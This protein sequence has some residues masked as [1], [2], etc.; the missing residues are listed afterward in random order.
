MNRRTFLAAA[1]TTTVAL[2]APA[3]KSLPRYDLICVEYWPDKLKKER[4]TNHLWRVRI[5]GGVAE[6]PAEV[7]TIG[8]VA[9]WEANW[10]RVHFDQYVVTRSAQVIDL[11][12]DAVI[13][14]Q[15]PC[16]LKG[17]EGERVVFE[18]KG[19]EDKW[20]L[21]AFDLTKRA[22]VELASP[23]RWELPGIASPNGTRSIDRVRKKNGFFF[24]HE[25]VVHTLGR[26]PESLG[27]GFDYQASAASIDLSV[28]GGGTP[29]L[30]L[31]ENRILTQSDN[32]KLLTVDVAAGKRGEEIFAP[33]TDRLAGPPRL[34]RDAVGNILYDAGEG[35]HV[36]DVKA[37]TAEP[38][39]W[40]QL[41]HEFEVSVQEDEKEGVTFRH[42]G[43]AIGHGFGVSKWERVCPGYLA[44]EEVGTNGRRYPY[45]HGDV[46]VRVW[47]AATGEWTTPITQADNLVGWVRT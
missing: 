31:D 24:T 35:I 3:P 38:Y 42:K 28:F 27:T 43:K 6:K 39:E 36:I 13:H 34:E 11:A 16:Q 47:S 9:D 46:Q 29:A 15:R 22:M 44:Y 33:S 14:N 10:Y 37:G 17:V 8:P 30:W 45:R 12:A 25:F 41:G 21:A 40:R 18:V 32:G 4:G 7:A 23:N 2:A 20:V 1:A 5:C 26:E 19:A